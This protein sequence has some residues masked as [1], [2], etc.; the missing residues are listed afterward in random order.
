M[1]SSCCPKCGN[2][3]FEVAENTPKKA[4]YRIWF[5]QCTSCGAVVGAMEY[6]HI[7]KLIYKLAEK[8][9]IDLDK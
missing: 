9:N 3:S 1:A 6:A 5:I 8:L 2:T 4:N 7:G